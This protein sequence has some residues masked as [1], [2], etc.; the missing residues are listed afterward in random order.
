MQQKYYLHVL[1]LIPP[2]FHVPTSGC[3]GTRPAHPAIRTL[4]TLNST[5]LRV[6]VGVDIGI[7]IIPDQTRSSHCGDSV[8]DSDSIRGVFRVLDG[9]ICSLESAN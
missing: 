7:G 4:H 1:C 3:G 2:K 5:C 6:G 8:S 9:R